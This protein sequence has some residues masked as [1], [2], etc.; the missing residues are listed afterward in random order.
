MGLRCSYAPV[1]AGFRVSM[2]AAGGSKPHLSQKV[3]P[4]K[5]R[6][7]TEVV[8]AAVTCRTRLRYLSS[9]LVRSVGSRPGI[10]QNRS[11]FRIF[12]CNALHHVEA[13]K[14]QVVRVGFISTSCADPIWSRV[15]DW[16]RRTCPGGSWRLRSPLVAEPPSSISQG[17]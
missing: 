14:W 10:M 9:D 8:A 12:K 11:R 6:C 16:G 2:S 3:K 13:Y 5:H 1:T 7:A 17:D 15:F 4:R